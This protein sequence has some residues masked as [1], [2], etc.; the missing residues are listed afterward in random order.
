M[1]EKPEPARNRPEPTA[2]NRPS[3]RTVT[4]VAITVFVIIAAI[5]AATLFGVFDSPAWTQS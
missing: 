3:K 4:I 5:C 1:A 2:R